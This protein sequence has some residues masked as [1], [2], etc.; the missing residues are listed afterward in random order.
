MAVI[1]MFFFFL[2][3]ELFYNNVSLNVHSSVVT[4]RL[5]SDA[6]KRDPW[7]RPRDGLEEPSAGTTGAPGPALRRL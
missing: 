1:F 6:L 4:V 3:G 5:S 2:S 7:L